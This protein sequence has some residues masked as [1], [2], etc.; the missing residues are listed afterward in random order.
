MPTWILVSSAFVFVASS[1]ALVVMLWSP[2]KEERGRE[3]LKAGKVEEPRPAPGAPDP[4]AALPRRSADGS[5]TGVTLNPVLSRAE[6]PPAAPRAAVLAHP[7]HAILVK[8][9]EAGTLDLPLLPRITGEVLAKCSD[10]NCVAKEVAKAIESDPTLTAHVLR[11]ANSAAYAPEQPVTSLELGIMRLGLDTV[12]DITVTVAMR[13]RLFKGNDMKE[14]A[15]YIMQHSALTAAFARDIA[16]LVPGVDPSL[17]SLAGLLHD[18]GRPAL[19]QACQD[20]ADELTEETPDE[21]IFGCLAEYHDD[22]GGKLVVDW[23]L[24]EVIGW[25]VAHHHATDGM[26]AEDESTTL[27]LVIHLADELAKWAHNEDAERP[28]DLRESPVLTTLGISQD[29]FD[30]LLL[31]RGNA[32]ELAA[33]YLP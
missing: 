16:S 13:G 30:R 8:R 31:G 5:A 11:V 15:L 22:V 20:I 33:S 18:I 17:A 32:R 19:R 2:S 7:L 4:P 10:P 25:A 12:K 28:S 26:D 6:A 9:I 21:I 14:H 27:A 3:S 23:Q 24:P 1:I 29:A